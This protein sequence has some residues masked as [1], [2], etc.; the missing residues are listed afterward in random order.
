MCRGFPLP[1]LAQQPL[2]SWHPLLSHQT[3]MGWE[4]QREMGPTTKRQDVS[5]APH[6]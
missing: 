2:F 3:V 6:A 1:G 5:R 4:M